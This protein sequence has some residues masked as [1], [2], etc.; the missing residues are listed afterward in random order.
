MDGHST[1][2]PGPQTPRK[3]DRRAGPVTD[4]TLR[5]E[6]CVDWRVRDNG[7]LDFW[8]YQRSAVLVC[9]ARPRR[10]PS[11]LLQRRWTGPM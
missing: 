5:G 8:G 2:E 10:A 6:R 9:R 11:T 7:A 4:S 3:R 1:G